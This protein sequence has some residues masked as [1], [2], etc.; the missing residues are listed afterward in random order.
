MV[1][2]WFTFSWLF[3]DCLLI[4]SFQKIQKIAYVHIVYIR[5]KS[6]K[7]QSLI[8]KSQ[9]K[10]KKKS[11]KK[12]KKMRVRKKKSK[13]FSKVKFFD[14]FPNIFKVTH[15]RSSE[16]QRVQIYTLFV[17]FEHTPCFRISGAFHGRLRDVYRFVLSM[18]K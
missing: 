15:R 3:V 12:S 2:F 9:T 4:K 11:K 5:K 10:V 18:Y 16:Q 14:A 8:K 6:I 1:D 17:A 13:N 7:S